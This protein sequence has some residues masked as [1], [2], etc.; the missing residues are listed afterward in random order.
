MHVSLALHAAESLEDVR[1]AGSRATHTHAQNVALQVREVCLMGDVA[2]TIKIMPVSVETDLKELTKKLIA[3]LPAGA[4]FGTSKEVP[5]A[6]G[7]KAIMMVVLV[8]DME[9][10]TE[11]VEEALAAVEGVENV[12]VTEVGRPV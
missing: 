5:I 6:F 1:A 2:A 4:E 12:M 9:G 3:A 8:G 10:G 7:I 11:K